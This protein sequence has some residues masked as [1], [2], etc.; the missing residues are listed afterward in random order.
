LRDGLAEA[1][2][3][4]VASSI[5]L[6]EPIKAVH[7]RLDTS[8]H[9]LCKMRHCIGLAVKLLFDSIELAVQFFLKLCEHA[10]DK[11]LV[12]LLLDNHIPLDQLALKVLF[13]NLVLL[14][15]TGVTGGDYVLVDLAVAYAATRTSE[16]T[17]QFVEVPVM[18]SAVS[19]MPA[20]EPAAAKNR[21]QNQ[22]YDQKTAAA[23]ETAKAT[24]TATTYDVIF[25]LITCQNNLSFLKKYLYKRN[26]RIV[27][28]LL[29]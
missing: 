2:I 7:L 17:T 14:Q 27:A 26:M 10:T 21:E 28:K 12:L 13:Q 4:A 20:K 6:A 15:N 1:T 22:K 29:I 24:E 3:I 16:P 25:Y 19:V 8:I 9:S 23:S 18:I 11:E 5:T